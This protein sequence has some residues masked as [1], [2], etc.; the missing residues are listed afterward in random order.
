M[1]RLQWDLVEEMR[2]LT[3]L[4]SRPRVDLDRAL[5][6]L[7]GTLEIERQIS[8]PTWSYSFGSRTS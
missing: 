1:T 2:E 7:G 8:R 4:V 6:R 3:D 5:D